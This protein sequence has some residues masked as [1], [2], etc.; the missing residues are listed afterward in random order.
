MTKKKTKKKVVKK[1]SSKK[2]VVVASIVD[3][4]KPKILVFDIETKP[5][6][7]HVWS[8]WENNVGLNQIE[9]DWSVLSWSAKWL[10]APP[11][12][13]MYQDQRGVKDIDD[14][15]KLIQ[16][17]WNLLDEA[18]IVITQ[19]GKKFDVKKLNARF[20]LNGMSPPSSFRHID[21]QEIAKRHFAFTSNKLAYMTDKLC[22]VYKKLT[23]HGQFPGHMLWVECMKDNILAWQEMELYNKYDVLSLEELYHKLIVWDNRINFNVYSDSLDTICKCGGK[24][25]MKN[26]F[27]FTNAGKFQKSRCKSCGCEHRS[28]VNLL[29]KEKKDSLKTHTHPSKTE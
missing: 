7:G 18:D 3:P 17:I 1:V 4:N 14:D 25:F 29:S 24:D 10:D 2:K 19:N 21:T 27:Y 23:D 6:I 15:K 22:T 13:V 8:L 5:I 9:K 26:G 11:E 20:I 12:E 28:K 16:G